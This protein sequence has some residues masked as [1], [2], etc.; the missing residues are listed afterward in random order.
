M[1]HRLKKT[2]FAASI[3]SFSGIFFFSGCQAPDRPDLINV[4]AEITPLI[5]AFDGRAGVYIKDLVTS[6]EVGINADTLYPTASLI[7][8]PIMIGMFDRIERSEF[9]YQ[10]PLTYVDSL[11]YSDADLTGSSATALPFCFL[12]W[13]SFP[14]PKVTTQPVCGCR[15]WPE[16]A[17][18][19]ITGSKSR[20]SR[21]LG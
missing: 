4:A 9:D 14:F 3:I 17:P 6:Q 12:R 7:K 16:Q 13:F 19:S 8:V 11:F 21:T 1:L 18:P 20:A 15:S 5:D 2:V 10:Q